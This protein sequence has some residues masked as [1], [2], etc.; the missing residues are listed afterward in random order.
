MNESVNDDAVYKTGLAKQ[1]LIK[2]LP[3]PKG[4]ASTGVLVTLMMM[5]MSC[6][7]IE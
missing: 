5:K 6:V 2:M 1:G 3:S 7:V 4:D